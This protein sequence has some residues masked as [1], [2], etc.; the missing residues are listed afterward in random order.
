[1]F[2]S[3]KHKQQ[4]QF[5]LTGIAVVWSCFQLFTAYYGLLPALQ[6]RS[7]HLLFALLIIYTIYPLTKNK[8]LEEQFSLGKILF[9]VLTLWSLSYV[10]MNHLNIWS[11]TS[12]ITVYQEITSLMILF[13]LLE[14][15]RRVIGWA[16]PII[17]LS[18]LGYSYFGNLLPGVL[19]H[20]G[21]T[22][23]EILRY[24]VMGLEGVFGIALGVA[25]TFVFLFI[26][27]AAVL[28]VSGGGDVFID[29]A[30]GLVG[31]VRGGPAKIAVVASCLFGSISG[32]A[33]ANVAGTGS[34][35]I[36][37]MKKTGYSARFSG[38]VEAV[39]STGGQLMPPIMGA[40]AFLIAEVLQIAFWEVALAAAIPALLY[41][42][43]VFI[44]VDVEAEKKG[45]KGLSKE[46][47]PSIKSTVSRGWHLLLSP[48]VLVFLLLVMQWSPMKAGFWAI[49]V[50]FLCTFINPKNRITL[51]KTV[52]CM[53]K[54]A[55]GAI[56]TT[57]ACA[58]VGIVVGVVMQ[59]GMGFQ[60]SSMLVN[61][62]NGNMFILLILT[63]V[64]CLIL[65]MGLPT[66]A[67]YLMLGVM[68]APTLV[69]MGIQ[70]LAAHLFIFYFGIISAITPP[71]AL[72][73]FVAAGISG[74]KPF[75]T[76]LVSLRLGIP[77]F[78]L[79]FMF[80]YDPSL[81]MQGE[82]SNIIVSVISAIIGIF[83]LSLG[84][85]QYFTRRL[86]LWESVSFSVIALAL[87]FPGYITDIVGVIALALLITCIKFSTRAI[88]NEVEVN[89]I[90][91]EGY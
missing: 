53:R 69:H 10:I 45:V 68:V 17:A 61:V 67:A 33:V 46:E 15:T 90:E 32:S 47:I 6:H 9:S 2:S 31:K 81:I 77:A 25:S 14:A 63:M 52:D 19:Y 24:Q 71:V 51:S 70:P 8:V 28:Q 42:L 35:T 54:G 91:E 44:M 26:L 11:Q 12:S 29:L 3:G 58:T 27:Y 43:A 20:K 57:V 66:V 75:S 48:L 86:K 64:T 56:E 16:L 82:L 76:S 74:D 85:Q 41:Y 60:L 5:T 21:Y 73:S 65:G 59:T 36:P 79:P 39:S 89:M 38:A 55:I 49:M 80:V 62:A 84:M 87:I 13:L 1:M 37:M 78:I 72:A 30:K 83:S 18:F 22:L 50:T 4:F 88:Q 40:A 23:S 34:F 7:I